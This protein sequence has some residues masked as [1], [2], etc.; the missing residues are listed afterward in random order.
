MKRRAKSWDLAM[1][2]GFEL[3][4][5]LIVCARGLTAPEHH[6]IADAL[7][8]YPILPST[9]LG[10]IVIE[11]DSS[12]PGELLDIQRDAGDG[13]LT[14]SDGERFYVLERGYAC[15]VPALSAA[16]PATFAVQP[17]F[18]IARAFGRLVRPALQVAILAR[19]GA[20]LHSAA[21]ELDGRAVLVAGW[22]E[23]GKTETALALVEQG[24]RFLSD[25][26][27]FLTDDR[28]ASVFPIT[29]GIRGWVLRYLPRLNAALGSRPR[30]RLRVA[31]G[32]RTITRPAAR[33]LVAGA[34]ERLL[35][36][37]DR[38]AVPP[39]T[40]RHL[41]G[42]DPRA[43]W[44]A[45]LAAV[46]LL[47]TVPA[48]GA[49]RAQRADPAWAAARL[50]VTADFERRRIFE[51]H[52]RARWSALEPDGELRHRL[53]LRE[54]ALLER[55]LADTVVIEVKAPFPTDPR[56]VAQAI[57]RLL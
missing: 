38:I 26:W 37:A 28:G 34:R 35:T 22:S 52:D 33:G 41:Y 16:L 39:S 20:A 19:R 46:A 49:V 31:A 9:E 36:L 15:A 12:I 30:T 23:S 6:A 50:A 29:V 32:M 1:N 47:T 14:A 27:T 10:D 44:Q 40:V 42:D 11:A 4:G 25:K 48:D 56:P 51:L 5:R 18:P 7:D 13:R 43:P 24:A 53:M 55:V 17:G 8:P 21:V 57:A 3:A 2:E 45:P 54:R